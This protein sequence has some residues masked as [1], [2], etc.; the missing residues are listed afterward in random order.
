MID[1]FLSVMRIVYI[2]VEFVNITQSLVPDLH[3][4]GNLSFEMDLSL[5]IFQLSHLFIIHWSHNLIAITVIEH[6]IRLPF[7]G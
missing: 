7:V 2:L 5:H 1:P 3:F 4:S 6:R